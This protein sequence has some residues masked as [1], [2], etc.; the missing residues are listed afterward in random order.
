ML[1]PVNSQR[2]GRV[3]LGTHSDM[4]VSC[5]ASGLAVTSVAPAGSSGAGSVIVSRLAGTL[6][7]LTTAYKQQ[8][9]PHCRALT[10]TRA[11]PPA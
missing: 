11:A 8:T 7:A 4:G 9:A 5:W 10:D 6:Q 1:A 3:V 2:H